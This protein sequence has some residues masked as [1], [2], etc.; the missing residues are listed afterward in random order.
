MRLIIEGYVDSVVDL[1][2]PVTGLAISGQKE[3]ACEYC[4]KEFSHKGLVFNQRYGTNLLFE[5]A[6]FV[7]Q[8]K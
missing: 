1:L 3:A 2:L 7:E 6:L 8:F 4:N 5:F